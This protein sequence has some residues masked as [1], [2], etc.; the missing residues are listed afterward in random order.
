MV[1]KHICIFVSVV[2][3]VCAAACHSTNSSE[4]S[5]APE[6]I[7]ASS[8]S[9]TDALSDIDSETEPSTDLDME[10]AP[11]A[12]DVTID[13]NESSSTDSDSDDPV[14]TDSSDVTSEVEGSSSNEQVSET[15]AAAW[16][17][18]RLPAY[19]FDLGDDEELHL[20]RDGE[21]IID[22]GI[23]WDTL[24]DVF[25]DEV[26]YYICYRYDTTGMDPERK[27]YDTFGTTPYSRLYDSD[28][29]LVSDWEQCRYYDA[30][31]DMVLKKFSPGSF[32]CTLWN[33]NED[34]SIISDVYYIDKVNDNRAL[35][36]D[37][38]HT[39]ICMIDHTG[40]I[41]VNLPDDYKI[42]E[43]HVDEG[44]IYAEIAYGDDDWHDAI[45]NGDFEVLPEKSEEPGLGS[46][47]YLYGDN[48]IRTISDDSVSKFYDASDHHLVY[49]T[50]AYVSYF[51]GDRI[52]TGWQDDMKLETTEGWHEDDSPVH[53]GDHILAGPFE[54]LLPLTETGVSEYFLAINTANNYASVIDR[55]GKAVSLYEGKQFNY[56]DIN[57]G[58]IVCHT[59]D[60]DDDNWEWHC[61][62][63]DINFDVIIP[64]SKGYSYIV[65]KDT[66]I[67]NPHCIWVCYR[68]NDY[69]EYSRNADVYN[70]DFEPIVQN[71]YLVGDNDENG[72]AIC[73]GFYIGIMGYDGSWIKRNSRFTMDTLD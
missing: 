35:C 1:N 72:F 29:N 57:D 66:E 68:N 26:A 39:P 62:L 5:K 60:V 41:A 10:T 69:Y 51:D 71:A 8:V 17:K 40:E 38:N 4:S 42:R 58:M 24:K 19:S 32:D 21:I 59:R 46:Y 70:E 36:V 47:S 73:K 23:Y 3:L 18:A 13:N 56:I 55:N 11:S 63:Y 61:A 33:P 43:A 7:T 64:E 48:Y 22:D 34:V 37:E 16:I 14:S 20:N 54:K 2:M 49:E 45:L 67:D 6:I 50:D 31:G 27:H 30:Y 12:D 25:T 52:I 53:A 15:D 44:I 28:G 65:S 9:A